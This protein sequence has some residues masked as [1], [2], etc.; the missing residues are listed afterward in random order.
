MTLVYTRGKCYS[1][2][3]VIRAPKLHKFWKRRRDAK[4]QLEAW[5][6]EV[7]LATWSKSADVK[8]RYPEASIVSSERVIFDICNN[9][10]RLVVVIKYKFHVVYIRFIG[11]HAEYDRIDAKEI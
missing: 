4:A 1:T 7:K 10:Y 2:M 5:Y 9:R 8:A 6:H 3:R 11:T